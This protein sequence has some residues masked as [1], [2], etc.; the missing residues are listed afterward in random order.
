MEPTTGRIEIC[1]WPPNFTGGNRGNRGS[2]ATSFP[3]L[4]PLTPVQNVPGLPKSPVAPWL[5]NL[6]FVVG[7]QFT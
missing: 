3:P 5:V 2:S 7:T 6:R 4:T 1:S